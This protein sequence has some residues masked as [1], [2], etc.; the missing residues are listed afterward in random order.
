[1]SETVGEFPWDHHTVHLPRCES[2]TGETGNESGD[3]EP[4]DEERHGHVDPDHD[5]P[6]LR[7]GEAAG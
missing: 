6:G 3:V 7:P 5:P 4:G 1:M 2:Q